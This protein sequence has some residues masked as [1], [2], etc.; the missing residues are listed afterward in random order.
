MSSTRA[1][2][3]LVV[4]AAVPGLWVA[5]PQALAA[6]N[7]RE[8]LRWRE[9]TSDHFVLKTDLPSKAARALIAQLEF[10]RAGLLE[11]VLDGKDEP[12]QRVEVV[13]FATQQE[14]APYA[15]E[16]G[17]LAFLDH[18]RGGERIVIGPLQDHV[19]ALDV[20]HELAHYFLFRR[21]PLQP[22]WYREGMAQFYASVS[23]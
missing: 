21:I 9:L 12:V 14:Y 3:V 18:R 10:S 13:A 1:L 23:R 11:A 17:A 15:G 4:L 22:P 19:R 20:S 16:N 8:S 6:E 5:T 2:A 7:A